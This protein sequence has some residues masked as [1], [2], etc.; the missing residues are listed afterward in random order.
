MSV[1]EC[2]VSS[3]T[4][5]TGL[6]CVHGW[7]LAHQLKTREHICNQAL[8][9]PA[10]CNAE[11]CRERV[12]QPRASLVAVL[13]MQKSL[14]RFLLKSARGRGGNGR[15][16]NWILIEVSNVLAAWRCNLQTPEAS[17]SLQSSPCAA[18]GV[19]TA[20]FCGPVPP[21]STCVPG[22]QP[23]LLSRSSHC[24]WLTANAINASSRQPETL[25]ARGVNNRALISYCAGALAQPLGRKS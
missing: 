25:Q 20:I 19:H 24:S 21:T 5:S 8:H 16:L 10:R 12:E 3:H 17:S 7:R 13:L 1:G 9:L 2:A 15:A 4:C 11:L 6:G 18:Q 14:Y 22:I 23:S